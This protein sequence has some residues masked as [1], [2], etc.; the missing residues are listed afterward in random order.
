M[1]WHFGRTWWITVLTIF[2][3]GLLGILSINGV[4]KPEEVA[5][6]AIA[7]AAACAS[8]NLGRAYEDGQRNKAAADADVGRRPKQPEGDR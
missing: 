4:V 2:V 5:A 1:K 7:V 8:H 6:P 3:E